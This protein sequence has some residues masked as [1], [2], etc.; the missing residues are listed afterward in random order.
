[1]RRIGVFCAVLLWGVGL[2]LPATNALAWELDAAGGFYWTYEWYEQRGMNGFFGPYNVDNGAGTRTANLNHW[3]PSRYNLAFATSVSTGWSYFRVEFRPEI[4][5]NEAIRFNAKM[6]LGSYGIPYASDYHTLDSLGT[7]FAISEGQWSQFWVTANTPWGVFA[8]GKRPWKFGNAL[9]Y[10][11]SDS[12]TSESLLLVAPFGPLDIGIGFYPY[13]FA[14]RSDIPAYRIIDPYDLPL[15]PTASG[16][17][18]PGQYFMLADK[19]GQF[20]KDL[21]LFTTYSSGPLQVGMLGTYGAY[22]IGPEALLQD[23]ANPPVTPLVP[24]DSDLTHGSAYVK[25][26]NGRFFFNAEAAWLYW[27]DRWHSDP[28][29]VVTPPNPR[30]VEQ[31]RYMVELGFMGG[32]LKASFLTAWTPGPDRRNGTLIGKQQAAF[33]WHPTYDSFL[34]NF[35]LFRP[36]SFIFAWNYGSGLNAYNFTRDGYVRDAFV[37]ATRVDYAVA[38]N[39]NAYGSFFWAQRT[40]GGYSWACLGPNETLF[41]GIPNDGLVNIVL[42]RYPNSPNIPDTALG[43][44]IGGGVDWKLLENWTASIAV[45]YWRPGKWFNY[46]CIDRSVPGWNA[47]TAANFFGTRPDRK[48]DPMLG[49]TLN[50]TFDF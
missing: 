23:S 13:R 31:W 48:I 36:Y 47:G 26:N 10:D 44:E 28:T 1:M 27:T 33:V 37:L 25:Y 43:Y 9:Q 15:Y 11:G 30:Y 45:G 19:S 14:G 34:G 41:S 7:D 29:G 5:L 17:L 2:C 42:N 38:A 39:L 50:L 21:L 35:S 12:S 6:R 8:I 22:H 4:R 24:Q 49:G 40:S 3:C 46:A 20:S 32:P 18:V 16:A